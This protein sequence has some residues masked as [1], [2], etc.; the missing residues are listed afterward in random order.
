MEAY[1]KYKFPSVRLCKS[2]ERLL[3]TLFFCL[4]FYTT[5]AQMAE[6]EALH[7][8]ISN[9]D[10]SKTETLFKK[11]RIVIYSALDN[12][13][14]V[15]ADT[16]KAKYSLDQTDDEYIWSLNSKKAMAL[17]FKS[18]G[19]TKDGDKTGAW[20][21]IS[22]A[23]QL[24][25]DNYENE[26]NIYLVI[27][28]YCFASFSTGHYRDVIWSVQKLKARGDWWF[29][30]SL[31]YTWGISLAV[32][33]DYEQAGQVFT[34]GIEKFPN[35]DWE[36]GFREWNI[37]MNF[38]N[39]DF[40]AAREMALSHSIKELDLSGLSAAEMNVAVW[41][42][43]SKHINNFVGMAEDH[44]MQYQLLFHLSQYH[45]LLRDGL[46]HE[47]LNTVD[48][49]SRNQVGKIA[50]QMAWRSINIYRSLPL[51]PLPPADLMEKS[52][53]AL[54]IIYSEPNKDLWNQAINDLVAVTRR[55]PWW[56]D[57]HYNLAVLMENRTHGSEWRY[58][59][60]QW[61]E[62]RFIAAQEYMFSV[63]AE[64]HGPQAD[65]ARKILK[66]WDQPIPE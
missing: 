8:G 50:Q 66:A 49:E 26:I 12:D 28:E 51:K 11:G 57:A 6:L 33:G 64:P 23:I 21:A 48:P 56:A 3:G 20:Q 38:M 37:V 30:A 43:L 32:L 45:R 31:Q 44:D 41:N 19:L 36:S 14:K 54:N 17:Y 52:R 13:N 60:Y 24:L 29:N 63:G 7:Y 34:E 18:K 40:V 47:Y 4:V 55:A 2:L 25:P 35:G 46:E 9:A 61:S 15:V 53:Q 1:K 27:Q 65:A 58:Y 39:K 5:S 10:R 22:E 62:Y 16:L 42:F 59:E